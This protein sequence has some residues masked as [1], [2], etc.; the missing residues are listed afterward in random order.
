MLCLMCDSKYH[1]IRQCPQKVA[2]SYFT[3]AIEGELEA[4]PNLENVTHNVKFQYFTKEFASPQA[5]YLA[6]SFG[7]A[8]LDTGCTKTVCG[9]LWLKD[10]AK[11]SNVEL[12]TSPSSSVYR[13]GDGELVRATKQVVLPMDLAGDLFNLECDV[14]S[15]DVPL[16][17]SLPTTETTETCPTVV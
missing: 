8:I 14:V 16:L 2:S 3:R 9:E 1:L 11:K 17:I 12:K 7:N 4:E 5:I 6:E 10:F 15:D 13:F